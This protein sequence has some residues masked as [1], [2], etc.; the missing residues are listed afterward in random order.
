VEF[1]AGSRVVGKVVYKLATKDDYK[2]GVLAPAPFK[3][4]SVYVVNPY[5]TYHPGI[6]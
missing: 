4:G 6:A 5:L 3:K 2:G 1:R